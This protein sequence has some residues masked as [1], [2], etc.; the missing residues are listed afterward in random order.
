MLKNDWPIF[1]CKVGQS[2]LIKIKLELDAWHRLL[3]LYTKFQIAIP[4]HIK[5]S[6][7]IVEKSKTRKNYRQNTK[8]MIFA[9]KRIFWREVYSKPALY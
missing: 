7:E 8:N 1:G 3:D 4:E 6:Q 2:V 5:Q 9:K